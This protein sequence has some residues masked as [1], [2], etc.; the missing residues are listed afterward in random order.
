MAGQAAMQWP[1]TRKQVLYQHNHLSIS[2]I[3][4]TMWIQEQRS[5]CRRHVL[6]QNFFSSTRACGDVL[7]FTLEWAIAH[8][9]R[10]QPGEWK[11]L[12]AGNAFDLYTSEEVLDLSTVTVGAAIS[13]V[14]GATN[15]TVT[16]PKLQTG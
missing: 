7:Q 11:V 16:K 5:R 13:T 14:A 12:F 15:E 8:Q 2:T 1:S 10:H 3:Q 4:T 6:P 9:A